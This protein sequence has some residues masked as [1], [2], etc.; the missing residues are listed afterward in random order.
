V[1]VASAEPYANLHFD[2]D[3]QPCQHPITQFF[4]G[5]IP[6]LPPNQQCQSVNRWALGWRWVPFAQ[7]PPIAPSSQQWLSS[8]NSL[9]NFSDSKCTGARC[10][11]K[12]INVHHGCVFNSLIETNNTHPQCS[13][14]RPHPLFQME[15]T[16]TCTGL[17]AKT[18]PEKSRFSPPYMYFL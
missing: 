2:P 6:F 4:T 10:V 1:A 5:R 17:L 12:R 9:S 16:L 7:A 11:R 15:R 14:K 18:K 3:T 8:S 13:I